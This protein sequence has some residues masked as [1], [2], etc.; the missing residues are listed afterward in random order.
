[1][2]QDTMKGMIKQVVDVQK[3]SDQK[4]ADLEEK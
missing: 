3:E 4:F 1:M 2:V